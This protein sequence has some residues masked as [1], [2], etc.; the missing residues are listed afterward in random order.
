LPQP[1]S[2][3]TD[4]SVPLMGSSGAILGYL[5][6]NPD[7]PGVALIRQASPALV[8]FGLLAA[9]VLWFLLRRLRHA[10][11][12]LHRSRSQ[13]EYLA[14]HD[15]LTGLPNRALF[16][17]RLRRALLAVSR[18]DRKIGLLYIDLDGFKTVNDTFGHPCGD[19]L[20]RQTA[21]R[22]EASVRQVDTVARLGGDEFAVIIFDIKGLRTAEE[23]C[24]RLLGE[25]GQPF[26]LMGNQVHVGASIG[27]AISSGPDT[28][29]DDLLRRADIALYE[30]KKNGRGRHE[31]F[32]GDMDDVLAQKRMIERDLRA[33]LAGGLD[34]KLFY[35]PIYARDCRTIVGAEALVRWNHPLHGSL[36]PA[37][38][39]SIAEERGMTNLLGG[40][41]LSEVARF[42]AG[43]DL[44]WVAFNVSPL[45][46]RDAGFADH[47]LGI[48]SEAGVPPSRIQIEIVESALLESSQTTRAV[49]SQLRGAGIR[50]ALDDFGTGYSSINYLKRHIIDKLK[51][52][53]SFVRM[54]D[55]TEGS[56]IVKAIVDLASALK[57]K[58][59]AEGVETPEQRDLLV[60]MG[61]DEL[62]GFLFSPGLEAR[63]LR[64]LGASLREPLSTASGGL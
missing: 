3:S 51:I 64:A 23:L 29:P 26:N 61:C 36:S 52:D 28:D 30:A 50:I 63:E 2:A 43:T 17:D 19:E 5:A 39:V 47:V 1:T 35:Q 46:L 40:W 24:E 8:G 6:W 38:F 37:L 12:E 53:H 22:L 55:T 7:R 58:V 33:A 15:T 16:E 57:V 42:A 27:V 34:I 11:G 14:F 13:A 20:V 25:L 44:P 31:V 49:L 62:Q 41:V 45:Q 48:L 4:A 60:K 54:L 32:A 10:T 9:G 18:D 59:T 21:A 56:A